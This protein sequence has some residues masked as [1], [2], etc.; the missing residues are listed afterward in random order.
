ME[1]E[2]GDLAED[3]GREAPERRQ[4]AARAAAF[5]GLVLWREHGG[6]LVEVL[7]FV[8]RP[9]AR[10][11]NFLDVLPPASSSNATNSAL[12]VRLAS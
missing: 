4:A 5:V 9:A 10:V 2:R 11:D 7:A 12:L 6:E 1:R 3:L 8:V